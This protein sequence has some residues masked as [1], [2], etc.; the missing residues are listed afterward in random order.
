L[1]SRFKSEGS[2]VHKGEVRSVSRRHRLRRVRDIE[3]I[4]SELR[5]AIRHM[6]REEKG[7]TP[8]TRY[9]STSALKS[10]A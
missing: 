7:R 5:L 4:D 1:K 6:V 2:A 8:S 9:I 3:A 10:T